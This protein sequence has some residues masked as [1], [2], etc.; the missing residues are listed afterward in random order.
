MRRLLLLLALLAPALPARA[1]LRQDAQVL[2]DQAA[3]ALPDLF[4]EVDPAARDQLAA[5]LREARGVLLCPRIL[6]AGFLFGGRGGGCVLL[7]REGAGWTHPAF[8]GMTGGGVGLQIGI[9]DLSLMMVVRTER[10]LSALMDSQFAVGADLGV[11]VASFGANLAGGTTA[12][13]GA[14]I[15]SVARARGLFLGATLEG[16]LLAARSQW[17]MAYFGEDL[18][19]RQIVL[20]AQG[21]NPGAD[22]L[23]ATLQRL[24]GR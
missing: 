1:E 17:N 9:Q 6:R 14:D 20:Q 19:A 16:S 13:G 3:T 12:A 8:Y 18:S 11:S 2:V 15:V 24:S 4:A 23:R 5:L 21:R 22:R 10:G 7:G